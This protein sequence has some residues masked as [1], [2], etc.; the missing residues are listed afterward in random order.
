MI[1]T[2]PIITFLKSEAI[3]LG[4]L[5]LFGWILTFCFETGY[6]SFF[7]LPANFVEVGL[8]QTLAVS[9][10]IFCVAYAIS[11]LH[12]HSA[13]NL[14][15][16]G[17]ISTDLVCLIIFLAVTTTIIWI[18][19]DKPLPVWAL[20]ISF[21][22]IG[23]SVLIATTILIRLGFF[24]AR[25]FIKKVSLASLTIYLLMGVL[26]FVLFA[27]HFS[28]IAVASIQNT[29]VFKKEDSQQ[30]LVRRYGDSYIFKGIDRKTLRQNEDIQVF[31]I[32]DGKVLEL[33]RD[34][35]GKMHQD[36]ASQLCENV[37]DSLQKWNDVF[38]RYD[39]IFFKV[40]PHPL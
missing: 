6:L 2:N 28:G 20:I 35:I 22:C 1:N 9:L 10:G 40:A 3:I 19:R 23:C 37:M 5:P 39:Q 26:G 21:G 36:C 11:S 4:A 32:G 8:Q 30:F 34:A 14:V 17:S 38:V 31:K 13:S 33:H 24:F 15:L 18:F 27:A 12:L 29:F 7:G 16:K 25:A